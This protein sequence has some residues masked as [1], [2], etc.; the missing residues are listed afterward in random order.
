[1]VFF[2][3]GCRTQPI[4]RT[5]AAPPDLARSFDFAIAVDLA[6][7]VDLASSSCARHTRREVILSSISL[8]DPNPWAGQTVRLAL[9]LP[10]RDCDHMAD[11]EVTVQPG[12][13]TDFVTLLAH[14]WILDGS[15]GVASARRVP[16]VVPE[17]RVPNPILA[18]RDGAVGGTA[19]L[20][21]R[22]QSGVASDCT[23]VPTG[24]ACLENCQCVTG[25]ACIPTVGSGVCAFSCVNDFDCGSFC[26]PDGDP[27][28]TCYSGTA[29]VRPDDRPGLPCMCG[30]ECPD[31]ELCVAGQCIHPCT[32]ASE[33]PPAAD[34]CVAGLCVSGP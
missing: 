14:A 28:Y 6:R 33:C 20:D 23:T 12:D 7:P 18:I 11:V 29:P 24:G 17:P 19:R 16:R 27:P 4:E 21:V 22:L 10:L 34:H 15:C 25:V 32:T 9:E 3:A 2:I 30:G 5:D 8:L 31:G 1:L 26:N 13:A